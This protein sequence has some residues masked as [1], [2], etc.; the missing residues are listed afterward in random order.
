MKNKTDI[1]QH[2]TGINDLMN[3]MSAEEKEAFSNKLLTH[4]LFNDQHETAKIK[5]GKIKNRLS[6]KEKQ[7]I[8]EL[9]RS[10]EHL[11]N[12]FGDNP[13]FF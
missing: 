11:K 13:C 9:A 12:T 8:R 3:Q 7:K 5:N 2:I 4:L 10:M 1:D 6:V